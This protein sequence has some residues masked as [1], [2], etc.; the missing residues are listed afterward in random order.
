[1]GVLKKLH[2]RPDKSSCPESEIRH[3]RKQSKETG[4]ERRRLIGVVATA[5]GSSALPG[6]AR[7]R[8]GTEGGPAGR[9]DGDPAYLAAA[10]ERHRG[11]YRGRAPETVPAETHQDLDLLG[12]VLNRP[13]PARDRAELAR[14]RGDGDAENGPRTEIEWGHKEPG[15]QPQPLPPDHPASCRR[16]L[17][18]AGGEHALAR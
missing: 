2:D 18:S 17:I 11:G 5:A 6:I 1:M 13:H 8:D 10:F 9:G 7:A 16:R 12:E 4:V 15:P 3:R 14:R